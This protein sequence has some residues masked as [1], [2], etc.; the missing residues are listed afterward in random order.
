MFDHVTLRVRDLPGTAPTYAAVLAALEIAQAA[1]GSELA[2]WEQFALAA[3]EPERP[4][5][6]DAHV[7]FH[8]PTQD[9]VDR[10]WTDGITA[11]LTDG[12]RPGL[13]PRYG[14]GYYAAYLVDPAGNRIEAV[15]RS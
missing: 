7:A 9:H 4:A 15:H 12:G 10:F 5:T 3:A 1:A 11:G 2:V 8:A 6:R 14:A 13:R